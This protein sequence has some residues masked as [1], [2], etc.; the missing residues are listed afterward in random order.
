MDMIS[1]IN[2]IL[3]K[4]SMISY[5]LKELAGLVENKVREISKI[6]AASLNCC[7]LAQLNTPEMMIIKRYICNDKKYSEID[8]KSLN[9]FNRLGMLLDVY[10]KFTQ[11]E[12]VFFEWMVSFLWIFLWFIEKYTFWKRVQYMVFWE[13]TDD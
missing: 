5:N 9:E 10:R 11:K 1:Q 2:E 4:S 7:G 13:C 12:P 6:H 8:E 3:H